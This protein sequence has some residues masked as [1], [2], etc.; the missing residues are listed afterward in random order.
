MDDTY[1]P[2]LVILL[3]MGIGIGVYFGVINPPKPAYD[4]DITYTKNTSVWF[5]RIPEIGFE[6]QINGITYHTKLPEGQYSIISWSRFDKADY[7]AQYIFLNGNISLT[8]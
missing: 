8:I 2:I 7:N 1:R 4:L 3:C 6:E 5:L